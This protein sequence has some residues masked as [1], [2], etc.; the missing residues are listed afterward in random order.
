MAMVVVPDTTDPAMMFWGRMGAL[1][2]FELHDWRAAEDA[3]YEG[4]LKAELLK[5]VRAAEGDL[6]PVEMLYGIEIHGS[7][8]G[9]VAYAFLPGEGKKGVFLFGQTKAIRHVVSMQAKGNTLGKNPALGVARATVWEKHNIGMYVNGGTALEFVSS[10]FDTFSSINMWGWDDDEDAEAVDRD[11]AENQRNPVPRLAQFFGGAAIFGAQRS[12]D[13][14]IEFRFAAAG[15]PGAEEFSKLSDHYRDVARNFEARDD[16]VRVR[17]AATTSFALRGEP[18]ATVESLVE[19][20]H[21][22]RPEW[23]IDPFGT[24]NDKPSTRTYAI[25]PA[26]KDV[27]IRQAILLAHQ[28]EPGLDGKHLAILWNRHVVALTPEQLKS[29]LERAAKG[30][31]LD[32]AMYSVLLKPLHERE[33]GRPPFAPEVVRAK[34]M[35]EVVVI[36]DDGEEETIEVEPKDAAGQVEKTLDEGAEAKKE[37]APDKETP[38]EEPAK[39]EEAPKKEDDG[40]SR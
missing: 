21:L 32:E 6:S 13:A 9:Q 22:V 36:D 16:L 12:G 25:A 35:V 2:M 24:D 11:D 37:T 40:K 26:P 34:R 39:K 20:G 19:A 14:L 38:K 33:P 1:G 4:L 23:A 29:A 8:D 30:E 10:I 7:S 31:P 5:G 18:A 28:R 3:L 27:D 15:I 17:E